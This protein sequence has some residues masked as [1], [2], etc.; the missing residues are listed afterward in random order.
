MGIMVIMGVLILTIVISAIIGWQNSGYSSR[1]GV[2]NSASSTPEM[3]LLAVDDALVTTAT[4]DSVSADS[5][6]R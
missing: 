4:N 6:E 1:P 2:F 5:G 3:V